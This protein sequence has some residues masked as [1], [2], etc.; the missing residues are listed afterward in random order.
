MR[1]LGLWKMRIGIIAA[2]GHLIPSTISSC[3]ALG[4][5]KLRLLTSCPIEAPPARQYTSLL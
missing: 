1:G 4:Y 5:W 3:L 2:K